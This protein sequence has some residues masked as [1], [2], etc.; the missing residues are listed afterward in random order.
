M[1]VGS[2]WGNHIKISVFGESHGPGIGIVIDGLPAGFPIDEDET[3][4]FLARRAPGRTPWSTSRREADRPEF[5]SGLYR[6]KTTGAPL[7]GLIRNTDQRSTDYDAIKMKPRPGHADLTAH[8][9]Y[10]GYQDARGGGHFSGRLTAPLVFAGAICSQIIRERHVYSS[11]HILDIAGVKDSPFDPM[12]ADE[13]LYRAL[14]GKAFPVMDDKVGQDMVQAVLAAAEAG[15]SVGGIIEGIVTGLPAGLGNPMFGG[16]ESCLS[17]LLFGIPAIKGIAF[18]SGFQAAHMRGSE[19]N[20]PMYHEG[21]TIRYR[22]NHNGGVLGG[23]STGLPVVFHVVVKP[24]PSIAQEQ[25][26]VNLETHADEQL[27]IKGRHDPCIVPRAVPV[28]DAAASIF[29]LD[30]LLDQGAW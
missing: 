10:H 24:T 9:R 16:I 12:I 27:Q 28:I 30:L 11:A 19:Y 29:A 25:Q 23:I 5:I 2:T 3:A 21:K 6:G 14:S 18:G 7:C 13:P 15:D 17:S 1:F 4:R 20:D 22:S 26:T 8:I